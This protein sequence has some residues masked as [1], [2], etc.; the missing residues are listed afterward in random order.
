MA[1]VPL[2][3]NMRSLFARRAGTLLTVVSIACT[4]A[5][6]AGILM[7]QQGF[8]TLFAERGRDDIAVFLRPGATSEGQS[9][10]RREQAELLIKETPEIALDATGKPLAS[11]ESFLAIRRF[12]LDGGET[13]VPIR[14][15]QQA[16][17]R[18]HGDDVRIVEGRSFEPGSDEVIVG[19]P[20]VNR[21]RG[22]KLGDVLQINT[23]PFRVVGLFDGKGQYG[24]EVWGDVER[25]LE[26]LERNDFSRVIGVLEPGTDL[27][28]LA[29]RLADD[30]RVP[31]KVETERAYL[32][33]QTTGT[34]ATFLFL[35][36]LLGVIMGV[37]AIFTG[38]NSML[39]G[40]SARSH[41]I[42]ILLSMGFRPGAIFLSFLFESVLL[43]LLGGILGCL[44]VLPL[45]GVQTGTTNFQTFSEFA[46]AFRLTPMVLITSVS[47]AILLGLV[48][49]TWPAARASRMT[50]TEALRRG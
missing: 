20:L 15:V 39:A 29:E 17:F 47:F 31:A 19:S 34:S 35:G 24:S 27:A 10:I 16:T 37:A 12:K 25:L 33:S 30:K 9:G 40:L 48:G 21:I 14:G 36:G 22:C 41:E 11:A 42:G 43:G 1:L 50:P 8:A 7:L 44:V 28:A 4:V 13:N 32:T 45:Q 3:Y 26:A 5:V 49:G 46:F 18:I 38:T 2:S 6:I 23:T